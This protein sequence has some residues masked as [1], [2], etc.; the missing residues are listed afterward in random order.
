MQNE[1]ENDRRI[2]TGM[3]HSKHKHTNKE[4]KENVNKTT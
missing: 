3:I 1:S 2:V 4:R